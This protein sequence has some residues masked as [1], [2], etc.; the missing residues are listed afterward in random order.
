MPKNKIDYD[1]DGVVTSADTELA[2][3]DT[4]KDGVVS[5]KE[6]K[7]ATASKAGT[8][9]TT[10]DAKT[11]ISTT[12]T[13]GA[14]EAKVKPKSATDFGF[15]ASFLKQHPELISLV[16]RA[17]EGGWDDKK[18]QD[19][20]DLTPFGQDRTKKQEAFDITWADPRK[21]ADLNNDIENQ[22]KQ[23]KEDAVARGLDISDQEIRDYAKETVRSGLT[24]LDS[25]LFFS[26]KFKM[27]GQGQTATGQAATILSDLQ[28]M[29]RSFGL[30]IDQGNLQKKVQDG[31]ASGDYATWLESQKGV[32]RQQA[33]NLYPTIGDQLDQYTYEDI[34]DPYMSDAAN[35]LGLNKATMNPMD[36]MWMTALHGG[37]GGKEGGSGVPMSRDEWMRT[38]RTD[39]K[40][41]FDR[42]EK[43]RKEYAGL[44]DELFAAF[45]MA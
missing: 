12:K 9:V 5:P 22:F 39:S 31:L 41:G 4:N 40:Y 29:A 7:A 36:P 10:T 18:F 21:M 14:K 28:D 1:K 16:N 25:R 23:F 33:K 35:L 20:F 42:T 2:S 43:A 38:L 26:A 44:T 32:F 15:N 37:T 8:Q 30:G 34:V 45:G 3:W 27:P 24:G 11:G 17:I 6:E 13:V 19:E